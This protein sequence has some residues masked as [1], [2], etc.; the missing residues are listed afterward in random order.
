M[1]RSTAEHGCSSVR[2]NP[3]YAGP[4]RTT[5]FPEIAVFALQLRLACTLL[6]TVTVLGQSGGQAK[7]LPSQKQAARQKGGGLKCVG[8][9][10]AWWA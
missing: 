9:L 6:L 5:K 3:T 7:R 2:L 10:S 8:W 4:Q 1:Y